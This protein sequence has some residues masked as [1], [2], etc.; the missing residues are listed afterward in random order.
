M[1][2]VGAEMDGR[3]PGRYR[4]CVQRDGNQLAKLAFKDMF[5]HLASD[6]NCSVVQ[7]VDR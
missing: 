5:H 1:S 6:V 3:R 2:P 4:D 7:R